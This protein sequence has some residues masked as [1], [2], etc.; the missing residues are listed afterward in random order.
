MGLAE[1]VVE[2]CNAAAGGPHEGARAAHAKGV[3]C[4]GTF[5]A[6]PEA[7]ALTRAA[8]IQGSPVPAT[9][10]FSNG[11]GDPHVHD[12][13]RDGRGM[14][15]KL[16]LPDG[17]RTDIVCVTLPSFLVRTPEDLLEFTRALTPD[18]ATGEPDM[19][20][21]GAYL[22]AHPEALPA[23]QGA[24]G[25]GPPPSYAQCAYNSLHAYALV[26]AAGERRFARY[27]WLPAA[28]EAELDD[29]D[30]MS[31]SPNYLRE[32]MAERLSREPAVFELVLRLAA[33]G[34][35]VNDPTAA[36]PEGERE[37]VLAGRLEITGLDQTREREG[38]VLVFDPTRV[39]DGIELSDDPVLLARPAAYSV[40]VAKRT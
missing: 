20:K 21:V 6:T 38:D 32:E 5:T 15:V 31:R 9:V 16:Y 37:E 14:A 23:I 26:D 35:D 4:E 12:G 34:D 30:A 33:D 24:I 7:A 11:S 19:E 40:S 27:R 39:T 17:S 18:P 25:K 3:V 29:A 36:W 22:A 1:E 10:R 8:H 28:G 2:A 13:Q